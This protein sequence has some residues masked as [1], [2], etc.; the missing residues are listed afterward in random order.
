M[1]RVIIEVQEPFFGLVLFD[2][3]PE[4]TRGTM[5]EN[6]CAIVQTVQSYANKTKITS[7]NLEVTNIVQ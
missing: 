7:L 3:T 6:H 5:V 2:D 4:E 1:L